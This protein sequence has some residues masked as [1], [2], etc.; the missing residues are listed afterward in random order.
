M[1]SEIL[2]TLSHLD[3]SGVLRTRGPFT[4]IDDFLGAVNDAQAG[5]E[6]ILANGSY[7]V[8]HNKD[9]KFSHRKGTAANP[10]IVRAETVGG[11][12]LQGS[13]G[14]KFDNCKFL[15]WY[16]FNHAHEGSSKEDGQ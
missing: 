11:V 8:S 14:Y 4:D 7:G 12:A 10:I 1:A 16:G 3:T 6:I 9:T 2:V 15:T 5:D 13:A